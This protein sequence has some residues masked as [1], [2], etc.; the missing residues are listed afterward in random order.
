MVM[1]MMERLTKSATAPVRSTTMAACWDV[2]TDLKGRKHLQA[3]TAINT[4]TTYLVTDGCF[5]MVPGDRV[6][7]P[8]GFKMQPKD[9][10]FCL[11]MLPRSGLPFK[12]GLVMPHGFGVMDYDY[13]DEYMIVLQ[14]TGDQRVTVKHGERMA[15]LRLTYVFDIEFIEVDKLPAVDSN[16]DGGHGST[17]D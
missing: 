4:K 9:N 5:S 8:T 11:D 13:Q 10:G 7:I 6:L 1:V 15:Q 12:K 16:R 14:N 3:Y 17:G 2:F